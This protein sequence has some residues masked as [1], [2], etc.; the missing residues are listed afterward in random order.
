[1]NISRPLSGRACASPPALRYAVDMSTDSSDLSGKL[2]IAMPGMDDPRFVKCVIFLCVHSEEG[3]MGLII[4]KPAPGL[5]LKDLLEQFDITSESEN[6]NMPI[7]FGGP[8]EHGRGFVLHSAEYMI[9]ESTL[10]VDGH[11]GMTATLDILQ[12]MAAG[13]GPARRILALGY[14]GWGSGQLED[15]IQ[16]NGWLACDASPDIVFSADNNGKWRA[17]LA[18]I[19]IDPTMLSSEAGRA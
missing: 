12:A 8:V 11:F 7:H 6:G 15:E 14:A 13:G 9:P 16:Q 10:R 2:L 18:S 4:N 17:A 19:G 1:M 3:S 5:S